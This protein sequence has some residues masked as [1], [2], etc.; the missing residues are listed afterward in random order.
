MVRFEFRNAFGCLDLENN[1]NIVCPSSSG[2]SYF[3]H[4][5][6]LLFAPAEL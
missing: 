4:A 2:V 6:N 3:C 5:V 1:V